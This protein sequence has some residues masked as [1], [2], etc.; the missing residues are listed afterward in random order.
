MTRAGQGRGAEFGA[1]EH[2]AGTVFAM[3]WLAACL[4]LAGL[5]IDV[6]NALRERERLR[7]TADVA[8][9]AGA[10]ALAQSGDARLALEA[11]RQAA[12]LNGPGQGQLFLEPDGDIV[13][14]HFDPVSNRLDP[15][16]LPNAVAVTVRRSR[17]TGNQVGTFLLGL[18]G[19]DA[20]EL[21]STSVAGV[22]DS[23]N[24]NP[25]QG[26]YARGT[27][28]LGRQTGIGAGICVHSQRYVGLGWPTGFAPGATLSMPDLAA[29]RLGCVNEINPGARD[30]AAEANL[31]LDRP[32]RR[33]EALFASFGKA[34]GTDPEAE[35]FFRRNPLAEDLSGLS[36]LGVKTKG[37]ETGGVVELLPLQV[38]RA[39]I[40]PAGLTYMVHCDDPAERIEIG[41]FG[42]RISGAV[43]LTDCALHMADPQALSDTLIVSRWIGTQDPALS[44]E[45]SAPGSCDGRLTSHVLV[46]GSVALAPGFQGSNLTIASGGD[47]TLAPL[48]M[49]G[50]TVQRGLALHARGNLRIGGGTQFE[51]CRADADGFAP[52]LEVIRE[53]EPENRPTGTVRFSG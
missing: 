40:L 23:Q 12:S 8:A 38:S 35:A 2:G 10:V 7:L 14:L 53:L 31:L 51:A 1:A 33:I 42:Q 27:I 41:G 19:F 17:Q 13:A 47:I 29:C 20:W 34:G 30:A 52:R 3:F 45:A 28:R 18:V 44:A 48:P 32:D 5:A 4:M 36:E 46:L 50:A 37:L 22:I 6:G 49:N 24:C 39:R 15:S 11:A 16:L 26:L 9:H 43:I 21:Q 25:L